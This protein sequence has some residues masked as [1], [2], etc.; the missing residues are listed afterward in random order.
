M[1]EFLKGDLGFRWERVLIGE[2]CTKLLFD[3]V[4]V[5]VSDYLGL[6]SQKVC[7]KMNFES[8]VEI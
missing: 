8:V 6:R 2:N 7:R 1:R 5:P 3:E 4:N